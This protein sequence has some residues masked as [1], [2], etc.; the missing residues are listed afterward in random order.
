MI[1][2]KTDLRA[3]RLQRSLTQ[4]GA[5]ELLGSKLV[6]YRTWEAGKERVRPVPRPIKLLAAAL[7]SLEK[8]KF[9]SNVT[10]FSPSPVKKSRELTRKFLGVQL[11]LP[12]GD[13]YFI[14]TWSFWDSSEPRQEFEQI[15]KN[16]PLDWNLCEV[17]ESIL[18]AEDWLASK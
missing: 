3:W 2:T 18:D 1:E 9:T 12:A 16:W 10:Q 17:F 6:T 11:L 14:F 5:A 4:A 8:T 15:I 7:D 13:H